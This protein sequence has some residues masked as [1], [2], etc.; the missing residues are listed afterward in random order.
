MS[1]A[2]FALGADESTGGY[3]A[4]GVS[5]LSA[6]F[7][8]Y[9]YIASM[10]YLASVQ[11]LVVL[12]AALMARNRDGCGWQC[13]GPAIRISHS[14]DLHLGSHSN[15]NSSSASHT[16]GSRIWWSC[17]CLKKQAALEIGRPVVIRDVDCS[18]ILPHE[19]ES[20]FE[21]DFFGLWIGLAQIQ[22]RLFEVL[23]VRAPE[24]KNASDLLSGI[25]KFDR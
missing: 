17:Y 21:T 13:L 7:G 18:Q 6:A 12:S 3:T 2:V 23:H 15:T 8:L 5:N 20:R 10:P 1:Y 14:L 9:S 25:G 19:I 22:N 4:I 24:F 11:A 16:L